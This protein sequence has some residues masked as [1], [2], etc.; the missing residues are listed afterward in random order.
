MNDDIMNIWIPF[1]LILMTLCREV[2]CHIALFLQEDD[3]DD[4][5]DTNECLVLLSLHLPSS[6][7]TAPCWVSMCCARS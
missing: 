5:D 6:L 1:E 7:V 4:N 3:D 2:A